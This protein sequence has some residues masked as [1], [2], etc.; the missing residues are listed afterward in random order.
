MIT[1]RLLRTAVR[2]DDVVPRGLHRARAVADRALRIVGRVRVAA[3]RSGN[4]K[5]EVEYVALLARSAWIL[6]AMRADR[7]ATLRVERASSLLRRVTHGRRVSHA[8]IAY[9]ERL[10]AQAR[11]FPR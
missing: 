3:A 1:L 9:V 7:L 4:L 5:A 8:T 6:Y 11:G 2:T 10:I